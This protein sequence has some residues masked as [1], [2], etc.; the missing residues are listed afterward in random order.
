MSPTPSLFTGFGRR[1]VA[2]PQ[3]EPIPGKNMVRNN[4]GG[5]T[6]ALDDFARLR[7]FLILGTSGGTYY[8]GER[9]LTKENLD[10]V[11]SLLKGGFGKEVVDLIVEISDAGRAASNDPAL[12][13]L[14]RCC[15]CDVHGMIEQTYPARSKVHTFMA[16]E[17]LPHVTVGG[18]TRIIEDGETAT[19]GSCT[20]SRSGLTCTFTWPERTRKVL[21]PDDVAVRQY[22]YAALH[23]VA[24][25]GTH[26]FHFMEFV[27]QFR[28]RGR[29][30]KRASRQWYDDKAISKL[31]YQVVKYQQRDG[32][33]HRDVLR[34]ARPSNARNERAEL[35][36]WIVKGTIETQPTVPD[37]LFLQVITGRITIDDIHRNDPVI[38][39]RA[40]DYA[41][42]VTSD[43]EMADL[44]TRYHLP[45]EAI[46]TQ[47]LN[48]TE[49]WEAL[50]E[51]DMP[52]EA[53]TR[54]LGVMTRNGTLT[55]L[56]PYTLRVVGRLRSAEAIQK[57]R[58]HPLKILAA[59]FTYQSGKS[60]RG[61]SEWRPL[62]LIADALNDAFY[63]SFKSVEPTGKRTMLAL[64]VSGSMH[65]GAING[66]PGMTPRVGAAAMALV[67]M[68]IEPWCI[69][70]AFSHVL[71]PCPISSRHRL[72]D[73]LAIM[74]RIPFGSTNC[75]LPMLWAA[76]NRVLV[77]AFVVYTD[78][79]TFYG[80]IH[81][82]QALQ[83][84]RQQMGID[85]KLIVVGMTAT[86][87]SIADPSDAGMLDCIGFDTATPAI[88]SSFI[89]GEF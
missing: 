2:T 6:F 37:D 11:E 38:L 87:F 39:A 46:P 82:V 49:V 22:A 4:A 27:K 78:N 17:N 57:A 72:N 65:G 88:I 23:K 64:D 31:A 52:M 24:R 28:G 7:R 9:K 42:K 30:H 85:A 34:L 75:A 5:Y 45:R 73:A 79:E 83:R 61:D 19:K 54:N 40:F 56:S 29:T 51:D 3:S 80:D 81:P 35:Y 15:A 76:Q 20:I 47:H 89:K 84:Y 70:V 8:V 60:A 53:M 86:G 71:T 25:I 69:A 44:I 36:R 59:L 18:T 13:A 21:H 14:A 10:V 68:A 41:K 16:E 26:L 66:I 32:W 67:T 62:H 74:D 77:E 33:S 48:S 58:L 55:P 12:F 63:A 1:A 43:K 50:L